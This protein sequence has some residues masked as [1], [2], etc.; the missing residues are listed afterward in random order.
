MNN[1]QLAVM[2]S[3]TMKK[4]ILFNFLI[5]VGVS[6]SGCH[7]NV[8]E[9][10]AYD[11]DVTKIKKYWGGYVPNHR[12]EVKADLFLSNVSRGDEAFAAIVPPDSYRQCGGLYSSPSTVTEYLD[13]PNRWPT[14]VGVIE[15]GTLIKCT[16]IRRSGTWLWPASIRVWGQM[17]NGSHKGVIAELNDISNY[18]E[19]GTYSPDKKFLKETEKD[20]Q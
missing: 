2:K 17:L 12:Y 15:E 14:T 3:I 11:K 4:L 18:K 7:P 9:I 5:F 1:D 16:M 19:N 8:Q 10:G 20:E 6:I 13:R